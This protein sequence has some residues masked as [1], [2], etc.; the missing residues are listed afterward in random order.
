MFGVRAE[1]GQVS[2][3]VQDRVQFVGPLGRPAPVR[4]AGGRTGKL[5]PR[6]GG[7]P[8]RLAL[9]EVERGLHLILYPSLQVDCDFKSLFHLKESLFTIYAAFVR[10]CYTGFSTLI[11]PVVVS[12]ILAVQNFH[13]ISPKC[14]S[15]SLRHLY[16]A[17]HQ[18]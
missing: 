16:A 15:Y 7:F 12:G 17:G 11:R 13:W 3:A 1:I 4:C 6:T 9:A 10:T 8:W 5:S 18:S 2:C 14:T